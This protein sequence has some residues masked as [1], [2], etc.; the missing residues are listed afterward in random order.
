MKKELIMMRGLP[1]SG[2]TTKAEKIVASNKNMYR[3]NRDLIREMLHFNKWSPRNEE[4]TIDNAEIMA[5]NLL[6]KDKSVVI[7]DTN[8]GEKHESLWRAVAEATEAEFRIV[9]MMDEVDIYQCFTNNEK[10]EGDLPNHV[11]NS[12]AIQYGYAGMDKIIIVDIDGT[13]ADC[14]HRRHHVEG[15]K[16]DWKAFFQN[17]EKDTP[18]T[19]VYDN[20]VNDAKAHDAEIVFVTARPEDHRE[21]TEQWLREN[22]MEGVGLLMRRKDDTRPDT[23]VKFDIYNRYLKQYNIIK[24]YD[25]R[26]AVIQM[27]RE[28]GLEVEDVGDGKDF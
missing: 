5:A 19:E 22:K 10:R 17:M 7:D 13:V 25:D 23:E 26:P 16:K 18:R 2:K 24:V 11:I 27:W 15:D 1:A 9:D 4:V 20:A 3:I 28:E 8:L 21:V 6:M 12:M 14:S